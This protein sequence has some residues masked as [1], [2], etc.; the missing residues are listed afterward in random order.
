MQHKSY[1][2]GNSFY[3]TRKFTNQRANIMKTRALKEIGILL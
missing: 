2:I 3:V 1:A